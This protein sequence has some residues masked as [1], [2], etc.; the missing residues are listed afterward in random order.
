MTTIIKNI[1]TIFTNN[2]RNLIFFKWLS[3]PQNMFAPWAL[4]SQSG[5]YHCV[6]YIS[7]FIPTK[8]MYT[9]LSNIIII[10]QVRLNIL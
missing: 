3:G 5:I 8:K 9:Q 6:L 2:Y 7:L 4:L 10:I 1:L